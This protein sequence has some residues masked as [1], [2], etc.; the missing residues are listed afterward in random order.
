MIGNNYEIEKQYLV[1]RFVTKK[2]LK[3]VMPELTKYRIS[4]STKEELFDQY[5]TQKEVTLQQVEQDLNAGMAANEVASFLLMTVSGIR[6]LEKDGILPVCRSEGFRAYG[7]FLSKKLYNISAVYRISIQQIDAWYE[8]NPRQNKE[9][10][11]E[12]LQALRGLAQ[13]TL[14]LPADRVCKMTFGQLNAAVS[15]NRREE[16]IFRIEEAMAETRKEKLRNKVAESMIKVVQEMIPANPA[17]AYPNARAMNRHFIIHVGPTNSGKTYQGLQAL[18]L[19][20]NG[21]YVAP[22]RLLAFEIQEHFLEK[23]ILCSMQTGEEESFIKGAHLMSCTAEMLDLSAMYDVAVVDEC[24]MLGDCTRGHSW[25]KAILGLQCPQ[26]HL[27]TAPEALNLILQLL[28]ACPN[29]TYEIVKHERSTPL[30]FNPD[31]YCLR[32]GVR[33][34]DAFIVFSR[35][36]VISLASMFKQNGYQVSMIYGSLPCATRK[37]QAQMF[38]SGENDILVATDAIGMGLN[39]PIHRIIFMGTRKFD[40]VSMRDLLPE[41]ILQIAGRSGRYGIYPE[42]YVQVYERAEEEKRWYIGECISG[43]IQPKQI[44]CAQLDMPD[45]LFHSEYSLDKVLS[46]WRDPS[47]LSHLSSSIYQPKAVGEELERYWCLKLSFAEDKQVRHLGADQW[48]MLL[49]MPV[50]TY[51]DT[52]RWYWCENCKLGLDGKSI[53]FPEQFST[54]KSLYSLETYNKLLSVYYQMCK[55]FNCTIESRLAS[56]RVRISNAIV[57]ILKKK[58]FQNLL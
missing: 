12:K 54:R 33:K 31:P 30:I 41:E 22:L 43:K 37:Q 47:I 2:W 16:M 10:H 39:L 21:V 40:G 8:K 56:E 24:Q 48:R 11:K 7:K 28:A 58:D 57:E 20:E 5:L 26:I 1:E 35:K 9:L 53:S 42:G 49:R 51:N 38:S 19:A 46:A 25:T 14:Q 17:D 55:R 50:D 27:C 36:A 44:S 6:K 29:D 52:I 15:A 4:K 32:D 3:E 23:N 18:E 34:G 13:E 45:Q